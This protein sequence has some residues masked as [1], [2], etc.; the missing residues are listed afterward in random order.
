MK[1]ER[2]VRG[3]CNIVDGSWVC[4]GP[5][6]PPP[7]SPPFLPPRSSLSFSLAAT[8]GG[9]THLGISPP[10]RSPPP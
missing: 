2:G 8:L 1:R 10:L 9:E 3:C 7:P 5:P 4:T 6:S